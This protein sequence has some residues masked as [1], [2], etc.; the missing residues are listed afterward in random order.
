MSVYKEGYHAV[1]LIQK[2]YK[3]IWPDACDEGT[4]VKEGDQTWKW[5]KQLCEWYGIKST[6][7]VSVINAGNKTVKIVVSL[8]NEWQPPYQVQYFEVSYYKAPRIPGGY[9]G[10][11]AI[12]EITN[13]TYI[14]KLKIAEKAQYFK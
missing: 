12:E 3:Q 5:V 6:R 2:G 7:E 13:P 14:Q 8:M 11:F 4:P 1:E 9:D 10:F